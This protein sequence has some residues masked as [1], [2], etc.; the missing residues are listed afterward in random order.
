[1]HGVARS[2][3][4]STRAKRASEQIGVRRT[5]AEIELKQRLQRAATLG[6]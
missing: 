4:A 6:M 2:H 5:T 3:L 1:V